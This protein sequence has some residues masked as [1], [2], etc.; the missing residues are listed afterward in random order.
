MSYTCKRYTYTAPVG[1]G[2][3][4]GPGCIIRE[5]QGHLETLTQ[6]HN[7]N[8]SPPILMKVIAASLKRF[9]IVYELFEQCMS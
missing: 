2:L 5:G 1:L 8:K 3:F 9:N 7:S 4:P 6:D